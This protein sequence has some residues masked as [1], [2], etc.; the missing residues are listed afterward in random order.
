MIEC[1]VCRK[2]HKATTRKEC[3]DCFDKRNVGVVKQRPSLP[4]NSTVTMSYVYPDNHMINLQDSFN[5]HGHNNTILPNQ[6]NNN[7]AN[8]RNNGMNLNYPTNTFSTNNR[9][10]LHDRNSRMS[11]P[12]IQDPQTTSIASNNPLFNSVQTP[13]N[14]TPFSPSNDAEY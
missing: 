7:T 12:H 9:S 4:T 13:V 1:S 11:S 10:M 14:H 5:F 3:K 8:M 2:K 6:D